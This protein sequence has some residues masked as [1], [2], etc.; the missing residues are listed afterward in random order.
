MYDRY[1]RPTATG[2]WQADVQGRLGS[3]PIERSDRPVATALVDYIVLPFSVAFG[4]VALFRIQFMHL[5]TDEL[6]STV[7]LK[8]QVGPGATTQRGPLLVDG[9]SQ[10]VDMVAEMRIP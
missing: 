2:R 3:R 4:A 9:C 1:H 7:S 6:T 5:F 8:R 10:G